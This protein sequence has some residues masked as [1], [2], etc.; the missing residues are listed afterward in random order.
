MSEKK[1][2]IL[3]QYSALQKEYD[4][5]VQCNRCG[6]CETVCPTYM[7][8]G[9][10]TLSPRGRAQAFRNILE[11]KLKNPASAM[12]IFS[13]CLTCHACTNV[14]YSEVPVGRLMGTARQ[15][16]QSPSSAK[17]MRAV[18]RLLL[19]QRKFLSAVLW[20]AFALQR[21]YI[22]RLLRK[23]GLLKLMSREMAAAE[24]LVE[25]APLCFGSTAPSSNQGGK[26]VSYF[27]ACG[28]KYLYPKSDQGCVDAAEKSGASVKC[29]SHS[30][31]GL[32][33]Q[34]AGDMNTAR[35]LAL[36]NIKQ[37]SG[38]ET[39]LVNDDSCAGFM[40][41]YPTLLPDH[42]EAVTF[43]SR[44]KNLSEHLVTD[45][46]NWGQRPILSE[47]RALSPIKVTY[48]DP[49]QMGNGQGSTSSPREIL[50]K[51]PGIEYV[52][53]EEANWCCG[54][55]GT[56]SLKHPDLADDV[57]ERKMDNIKKS[58]AEIVV[59][60]ASSCLLHVGY[61]LRKNVWG[62]KVRVLHLAEFLAEFSPASRS[63]PDEP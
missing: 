60:Q 5:A 27:S 25:K 4:A 46:M 19:F 16:A 3:P 8:S 51:I 18:F 53:L 10:E 41:A 12:D 57:L 43:A 11:G 29:G 14:C 47:N 54:G 13:T 21:T 50:K 45:V 28:I 62:E 35:E 22:P 24:E 39:I 6:F 55:A 52:E 56:Y 15:I 59:T 2:F 26:S 49:C 17:M 20:P 30:C 58:G 36:K 32:I 37:F 48:H 42:P 61:G 1:S 31:C 9:K 23:I 38:A 34:S 44:I 40:K 63:R 7:V 33:P